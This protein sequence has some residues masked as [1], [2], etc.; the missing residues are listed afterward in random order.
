MND[1][2]NVFLFHLF[3]SSISEKDEKDD[4]KVSIKNYFFIKLPS[5]SEPSKSV[6]YHYNEE[7]NELFLLERNYYNPKIETIRYE[8]E[9]INKNYISLFVNN[10]TIENDCGYYCYPIDALF[11]FISIIYNNYTHNTYTTLE[12]YLI[13]I[14]K[15]NI[16][17]R[18]DVTK[19]L[20]LILKNNVNNIKDRLKYVCDE[21]HENNIYY[22]K[23]NI[24]KVRKFYNLKCIILFNYIIENKIVFPDYSQ[25]IEQELLDKYKSYQN[26]NVNDNDISS[27]NPI[28]TLMKQNKQQIDKYNEYKKYV[29]NYLIEFNKKH[30]K[31]NAHNLRTFVWQIIKGFIC[32]SLC[33]QI[34]PQDISD[35]L[36]KMKEEETNKKIIQQNETFAKGKK[37]P[38]QQPPRNQLMIDSFFKKK[39]KLK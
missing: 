16:K 29:D 22:Y 8:S 32:I 38:L 27:T 11:V 26:N 33:E 7:T 18:K 1:D 19:N 15:D 20:L 13:F 28:Y 25:C 17:L 31:F 9:K 2:K 21:L 5:I 3:C 10:Y 24:N 4:G 36:K 23:P 39:V 37:H 6:L 34:T 30:Y 12:D 14:I 35:K